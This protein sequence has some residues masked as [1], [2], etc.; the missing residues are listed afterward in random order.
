MAERRKHER[1]RERLE[2][3]VTW[4]G[5][6]TELGRTRDF[7]DG[8]TFIEVSFGR[9]PPSG[10]EMTLQLN[11]PVM[12]REAPVLRVRVVWAD[13]AGIAFQ[14]VQAERQP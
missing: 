13:A 14:F 8:G 6:S 12:G 7:S 2:V 3:R 4:P 5:E 1:V 9:L 10:T 11:A